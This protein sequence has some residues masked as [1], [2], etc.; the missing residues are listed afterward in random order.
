MCSYVLFTLAKSSRVPITKSANILVRWF[1]FIG[2]GALRGAA[3]FIFVF[4]VEVQLPVSQ[5]EP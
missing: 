3:R 1:R 4:L 5:F 2:G